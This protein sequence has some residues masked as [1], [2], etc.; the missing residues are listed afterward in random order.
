MFRSLAL[1]LLLLTIS[2]SSIHAAATTP[3]S[4]A[5]SLKIVG[6]T[7][8]QSNEWP[9]MVALIFSTVDNAAD[10]FFCGGSLIG[11]SW[12]LTAAHCLEDE[13]KYTIEVV[14]NATDLVND[15]GQRIAIKR[16]IRHPG[17]NSRTVKN[18]IAL[19]K[20]DEPVSGAELVNLY[21]GSDTLEDTNAT[22]IGWGALSEADSDAGI[23]S[24]K[25]YDAVLP[26][27]SNDECAF[28]LPLDNIK[29]KQ[30]C[31]GFSAGGVDTCQGDSGGP[32]VFQDG[33]AWYQAG[34]TSY[35][36]GCARAG[37]YGVYTRVSRYISFIK[38]KM[39]RD[40]PS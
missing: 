37:V 11:E 23:V 16:I 31:A 1:A 26:I 8:S 13:N 35:G 39:K 3:T 15:T 38:S 18:D 4:K 10:G 33:G 32:L 36:E 30:L 29:S 17:Y 9:W 40:F 2:P 7:P 24:S 27:V 6:G 25:L 34:I 12:V 19:L 20:L 21:R 14:A 5:P 22:I 28:A